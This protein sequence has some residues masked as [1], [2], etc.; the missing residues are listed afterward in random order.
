[1]Y[2]SYVFSLELLISPFTFD[3]K[4]GMAAS[5]IS[6]LVI[7]FRPADNSASFKNSFFLN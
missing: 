3:Y 2:G 5:F 7:L 6:F 1:M 4:T